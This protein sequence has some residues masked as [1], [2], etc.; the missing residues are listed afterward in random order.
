MER[1]KE[2]QNQDPVLLGLIPAWPLSSHAFLEKSSS[3]L[4][5]SFH[6]CAVELARC[7]PAALGCREIPWIMKGPGK[8]VGL[9]FRG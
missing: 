5:V 7:L 9:A 8:C 2:K 4:R 3:F 6:L 1:H